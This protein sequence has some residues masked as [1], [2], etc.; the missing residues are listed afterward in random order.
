M[1]HLINNFNFFFS[2]VWLSILM[3]FVLEP[4]S[5][6]ISRN[7]IWSYG[8]PWKYLSQSMMRIRKI[9]SLSTKNHLFKEHSRIT[10]EVFCFCVCVYFSWQLWIAFSFS[11]LLFLP[12]HQ[13]KQSDFDF[14]W[15]KNLY[16]KL[17]IDYKE[18][19]FPRHGI[20]LAL[21]F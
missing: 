12:K 11:F 13:L 5:R 1:S 8:L 10:R 19:H 15:V 16:P 21:I 14:Q 4:R 3:A 6:D 2:Q 18:I 7:N 20:P 9:F 17:K